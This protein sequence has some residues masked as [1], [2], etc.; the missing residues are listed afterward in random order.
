MCQ[1]GA[2]YDHLEIQC[3]RSRLVYDQHVFYRQERGGMIAVGPAEA[4]LN[5]KPEVEQRRGGLE[6]TYLQTHRM[7]KDARVER[8]R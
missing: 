8:S 4:V 3:R 2:S 6:A 1:L 5:P 7:I